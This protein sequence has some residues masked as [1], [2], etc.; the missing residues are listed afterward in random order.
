MQWALDQ[1]DR[2]SYRSIGDD[3]ARQGTVRKAIHILTARRD[4][5]PVYIVDADEEDPVILGDGE[6]LEKLPPIAA[7][8]P[9]P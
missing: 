3:R 2:V 1:G 4:E 8:H 7:A 6:I 5:V 9:L